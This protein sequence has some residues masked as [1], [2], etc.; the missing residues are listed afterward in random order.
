MKDLTEG[1]IPRHIVDVA[2]PLA[3]GMIVQT[4]Y[5]LVDLYFVGK[6]G[7]TALA[8]VSAAAS[9]TFLIMAL[10]QI[11]GVGTVSLIAHATGRRDRD[12]A[13]LVFNQSLL[14]AAL[15]GA[16]TLIGGY[17]FTDA[18]LATI[19]ADAV[20]VEAGRTYLYWF[21]P[22]MALQFA[23]IAMSSALRGTG[24]VKPTVAVQLLTVIVNIIL[25]PVLIAGWGTGL[26][27]GVAGAGLATSVA[28]ACG[29]LLLLFYFRRL[30]K[31]VRLDAGL[32]RPRVVVWRR[33]LAIGLPAGGEFFLIFAFM[34]IIYWSI[35]DFGAEAQAGFGLG[36]RIMQSIFLPAMALAFAAPAV[37]GQNFGAR[38]AARVRL[39]F[40][41]TAVMSGLVMAALTLLCQISPSA[42]V[43][44]FSDDA[45]VIDVAATFLRFISWNFVPSAIIF[46]CSGMFQALGNT[47]PAL[48][49]TAVR[50]G[51]FA[52]PLMWAA[53]QEGFLIEHVWFLSVAT[54]ALQAIVSYIL[55]RREFRRSLDFPP[56]ADARSPDLLQPDVRIS[57]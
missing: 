19:A 9:S 43:R 13:N 15:L 29:V 48:F 41:W 30:E 45:A 8:G 56:S 47:W 40:R 18:Y 10:T 55:L 51:G 5:Y 4:L 14:L 2:V 3:V 17:A 28:V 25:A 57:T 54:M 39:T 44:G 42:L 12:D 24:I 6:I 35:R 46:T 27:M 16:T 50:L 31:Y 21:L 11:L 52:L 37:A 7:G 34:A 33:L 26:P 38:Q 32:W 49:S 20:T 22:G 23:L 36:Q 53:R 1:S